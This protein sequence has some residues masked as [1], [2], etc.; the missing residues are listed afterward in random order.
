MSKESSVNNRQ[1]PNLGDVLQLQATIE[2]ATLSLKNINVPSGPLQIN[3]FT[4]I[5]VHSYPEGIKQFGGREVGRI[6]LRMKEVD[7]NNF[8]PNIYYI[9]YRDEGDETTTWLH[10]RSPSDYSSNKSE[11]G[12]SQPTID[13][14]R[15]LGALLIETYRLEPIDQQQNKDVR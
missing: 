11:Q 1:A 7:S 2:A 12:L 6:T 5:S 4:Q 10:K 13:E 9:I 14:I 8:Q 3:D 15:C